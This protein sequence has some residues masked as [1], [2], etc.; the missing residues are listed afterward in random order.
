MDK[1]KLKLKIE[2][3]LMQSCV[4]DIFVVYVL[5]SAKKKRFLQTVKIPFVEYLVFLWII[6]IFRKYFKQLQ[7]VYFF[8]HFMYDD[9]E[10]FSLKIAVFIYYGYSQIPKL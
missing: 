9:K 3:F 6:E 4:R 7:S 5:S 2:P 10:L 8:F 1:N